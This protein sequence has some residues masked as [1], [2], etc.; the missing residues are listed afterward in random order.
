MNQKKSNMS[1]EYR[2]GMIIAYSCM[3]LSVIIPL[4]SVS[5]LGEKMNMSLFMLFSKR[6]MRDLGLLSNGGS[7]VAITF[8]RS[9]I[10]L[11]ILFAIAGILCYSLDI[12]SRIKEGVLITLVINPWLT[13]G[14]ITIVLLIGQIATAG[15]YAYDLLSAT[16]SAYRM[17][18][19]APLATLACAYAF[20]RPLVYLCM[21][22]PQGTVE[23]AQ[24]S[25]NGAKGQLRGIAG[26][27]AGQVIPLKD[28]EK[29][30]LGRS[31]EESNLIVDSPKVSR[32]HCEITFDRK[33]GTFVLRDYSYNGTY[34]I[35][36][37]KFEKHEILRPGTKFYLGNKDN[38]FQVE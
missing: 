3:L 22:K 24:P 35:T 1:L 33:N 28:G 14:T 21:Y 32:R 38:I 13:F 5:V 4:C 19:A 9:L 29:I 7:I 37:E 36:G 27:Y 23:T 18:L 34:K 10:I 17:G 2:I 31:A 12:A 20:F 11:Y 26:T 15:S 25:I 30:V 8:F 16:S 6:R